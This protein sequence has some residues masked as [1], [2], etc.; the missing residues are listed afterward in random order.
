MKRD[1]FYIPLNVNYLRKEDGKTLH[2]NPGEMLVYCMAQDKGYLRKDILD[3]TSVECGMH[4]HKLIKRLEGF[5]LFKV[6]HTD[7]NLVHLEWV[8]NMEEFL[9]I[10]V[11][12]EDHDEDMWEDE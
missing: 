10:C 4:P 11:M 1:Y 7:N 6:S 5:G 12:H 3:R 8:M 9:D 2:I